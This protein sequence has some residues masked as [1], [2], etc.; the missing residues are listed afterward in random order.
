VFSVSIRSAVH[1]SSLPTCSRSLRHTL[2]L[3]GN[4]RTERNK[5]NK[6]IKRTK[7]PRGGHHRGWLGKF[8]SAKCAIRAIRRPLLCR[9]VDSLPIGDASGQ[10]LDGARVI[11]PV[12]SKLSKLLNQGDA[13]SAP[14]YNAS[15][16]CS[17]QAPRR[18][19]ECCGQTWS[20]AL[21]SHYC[22]QS[23]K[24]SRRLALMLFRWLTAVVRRAKPMMRIPECRGCSVAAAPFQRAV[25]GSSDTSCS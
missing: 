22:L 20:V 10:N 1:R 11:W 3:C 14:C 8:M 13:P 16:F 15:Y 21:M 12:F 6:R 18:A 24:S 19:E 5:R 9:L 7:C 4:V 2:F 17:P 25:R 23:P